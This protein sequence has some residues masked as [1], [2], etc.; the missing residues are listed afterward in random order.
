MHLGSLRTPYWFFASCFCQCWHVYVFSL[1]TKETKVHRE[2]PTKQQVTQLRN[3]LYGAILL[4]VS[5]F[6]R[7]LTLNSFG[8]F[9]LSFGLLA[10]FSCC[11][12]GGS[13]IAGRCHGLVTRLH[14]SE[15]NWRCPGPLPAVLTRA[16]C[17]QQ[18]LPSWLVLVLESSDNCPT[19]WVSECFLLYCL[20]Q[21][22]LF[23][24]FI[25][26]YCIHWMMAMFLCK[27]L[28]RMCYVTIVFAPSACRIWL[29][30]Y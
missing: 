4:P 25:A 20:R 13:G 10:G 30:F 18:S 19:H 28:N 27:C 5:L 11:C 17:A 8:C 3:S 9:C 6:G 12:S 26:L 1:D 21:M 14:C 15:W 29:R 2:P 24:H 22:S 16:P 7:L 23:F